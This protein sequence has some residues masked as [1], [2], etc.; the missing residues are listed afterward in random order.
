MPLSGRYI[1]LLLLGAVAGTLMLGFIARDA[2]GASMGAFYGVT[3]AGCW[4]VLHFLTKR[5][6]SASR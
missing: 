5:A 2:Q 3:T 6:F 1:L 4:I